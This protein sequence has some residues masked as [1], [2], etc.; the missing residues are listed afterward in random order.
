MRSVVP[1]LIC[2]HED[3]CDAW[4]TDEYAMGVDNWRD[5]LGGWEYDPH[6]DTEAAYCPEHKG[7]HR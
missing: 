1:V 6:R 2:D 5:C 7:E 4:I 3:A